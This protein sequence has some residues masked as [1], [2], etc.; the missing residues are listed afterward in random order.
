MTTIKQA[1]ALLAAA[2][3]ALSVLPIAQAGDRSEA[4]VLSDSAHPINKASSKSVYYGDLDVSTSEGVAAL[5]SRLQAAAK[6][7]CA[8]SIDNRSVAAKRAAR[9]CEERALKT[10][11][12]RVDNLIRERQL[13]AR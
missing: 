9:A 7:V 4:T 10:A 5:T 1:G 3:L 11:L 2:T 8:P 13:A 6:K 12:A